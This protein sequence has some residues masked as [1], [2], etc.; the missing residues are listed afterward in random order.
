MMALTDNK[1][2]LVSIRS[3]GQQTEKAYLDL[4]NKEGSRRFACIYQP[5]EEEAA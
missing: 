5:P 2:N 1:V 4:V 3:I